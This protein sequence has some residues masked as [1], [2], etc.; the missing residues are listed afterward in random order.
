MKLFSIPEVL[1]RD[2]V[3]VVFMFCKILALGSLDLGEIGF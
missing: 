1:N 3:P 2:F